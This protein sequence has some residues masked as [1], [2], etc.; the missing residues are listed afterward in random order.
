MKSFEF[1]KLSIK[2][3]KPLLITEVFRKSKWMTNCIPITVILAEEV[4]EPAGLFAVT[5]YSP[6]SVSEQESILNVHRPFWHDAVTPFVFV[7]IGFL[8]FCQASS[9]GSAATLMVAVSSSLL[10]SSMVASLRA[11]MKTGAAAAN[12][13]FVK[14]WRKE[15]RLLEFANPANS[16]II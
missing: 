2:I 4:M 13:E 9:T 6:A 1:E 15:V 10:P 12:R 8:S 7:S 11:A 3:K 16:W 5:E 14:V